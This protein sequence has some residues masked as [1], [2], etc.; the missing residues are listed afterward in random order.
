LRAGIEQGRKNGAIA[1]Q[2][3][4]DI[5]MVRERQLS[6]RNNYRSPMV[7]PHGVERDAGFMGHGATVPRQREDTT[8]EP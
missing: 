1:E 6:S 2:Q 8:G 7:S 3:K 4:F 5:W